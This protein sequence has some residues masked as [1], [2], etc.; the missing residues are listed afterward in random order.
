MFDIYLSDKHDLL[1]VTKGSSI[2]M[3]ASG[4]WRKKKKRVRSV[5][6]EIKSAIDKQGYYIRKVGG[7]KK[8]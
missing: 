8:N 4:R 1:V 7:S 6:D 5:S 2:S 3:C